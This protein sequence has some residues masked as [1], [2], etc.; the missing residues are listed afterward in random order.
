MERTVCVHLPLVVAYLAYPQTASCLRASNV[1]ASTRRGSIVA[2][3]RWRIWGNKSD[4]ERELVVVGADMIS[5][6]WRCRWSDWSP[7]ETLYWQH[8]QT[9]PTTSYLYLH[10]RTYLNLKSEQVG[11]SNSHWE[12]FSPKQL[13]TYSCQLIVIDPSQYPPLTSKKWLITVNRGAKGGESPFTRLL[14][15]GEI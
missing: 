1:R 10:L 8:L 4:R 7:N 11:K 12:L 13:P 3:W 9:V 14:W 5:A 6:R 15:I 2:R